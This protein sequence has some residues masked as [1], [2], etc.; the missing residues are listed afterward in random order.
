MEPCQN[1]ILHVLDVLHT[2]RSHEGLYVMHEGL[3]VMQSVCLS[4]GLTA[5]MIHM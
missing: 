5:I 4:H 1:Y 3:H 2:F